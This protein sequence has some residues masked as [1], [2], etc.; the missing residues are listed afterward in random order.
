MSDTPAESVKTGAVVGVN[1]GVRREVNRRVGQVKR[2]GKEIPSAVSK[3]EE[4]GRLRSGRHL[5]RSLSGIMYTEEQRAA[6][7]VYSCVRK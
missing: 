1:D 2:R 3:T 6:E 7:V 4:G 5:R